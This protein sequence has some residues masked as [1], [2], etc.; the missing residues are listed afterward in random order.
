VTITATTAGAVG[1]GSGAIRVAKRSW[2]DLTAQDDPAPG[3]VGRSGC[4]HTFRQGRSARV[5]ACRSGPRRRS[6][7]GRRRAASLCRGSRSGYGRSRSR[8]SDQ[9]VSCAERATRAAWVPSRGFVV[10]ATRC[11]QLAWASAVVQPPAV[12]GARL[13]KLDWVVFQ[14]PVQP[15]GGTRLEL[16]AATAGVAA[17]RLM[18]DAAAAVARPQRSDMRSPPRC[19]DDFFT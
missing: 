3:T 18:T 7:T 16:G 14:P 19:K 5:A 4:R 10:W 15:G 17:P 8:G 11:L 1:A 12:P 2:R 6:L 9:C 13:W